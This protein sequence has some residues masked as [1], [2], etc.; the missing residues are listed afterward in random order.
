MFSMITVTVSCCGYGVYCTGIKLEF[1]DWRFCL[2]SIAIGYRSCIR[3]LIVSFSAVLV[4][5]KLTAIDFFFKDLSSNKLLRGLPA[6]INQEQ[7]E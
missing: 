2:C 4:F 7:R 5:G 6:S 1:Y 3:H